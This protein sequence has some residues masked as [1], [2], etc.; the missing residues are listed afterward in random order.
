MICVIDGSYS[1]S[2]ILINVKSV[3]MLHVCITVF[4]VLSQKKQILKLTAD[5]CFTRTISSTCEDASALFRL[6]IVH[7]VTDS[8]ATWYKLSLRRRCALELVRKPLVDMLVIPELGESREWKREGER[9]EGE[10]GFCRPQEKPSALC[11]RSLSTPT[12]R[13]ALTLTTPRV[14]AVIQVTLPAL[15]MWRDI[16]MKV[17]WSGILDKCSVRFRCSA[18]Y[19]CDF[20]WNCL[21]FGVADD[22]RL[23]WVLWSGR[24]E[25]WGRARRKNPAM[26][27]TSTTRRRQRRRTWR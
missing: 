2:C 12:D 23:D 14:R 8:A 27:S 19:F 26:T 15:Q 6:Y 4:A 16:W 10:A 13:A 17:A 20:L 21:A 1:W 11:S 7:M 24:P 25:P 5:N 9:G 18:H 22:K 3:A